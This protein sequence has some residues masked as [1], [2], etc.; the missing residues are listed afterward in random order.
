MR[1]LLAAASGLLTLSMFGQFHRAS[2]TVDLMPGLAYNYRMLA[3]KQSPLATSVGVGVQQPLGSHGFGL[4][5]G[6]YL[7]HR[8]FK[9][10][11]DDFNSSGQY[12]GQGTWQGRVYYLTLPVSVRFE[13][14]RLVV[15]GG[16]HIGYFMSSRY[17][18]RD[19][20]G[21]RIETGTR[22]TGRQEWPIG[23]QL[24]GGWSTV[25]TGGVLFVVG[26]YLSDASSAGYI[27]YGLMIRVGRGDRL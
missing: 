16:A 22:P 3:S 10:R 6:L 14:R 15:C 7:M 23:W 26:L 8:G 20:R 21:I 27:N 12:M 11:L 18:S 5:T 1:L 25:T 13:R 17:I 2:L 24:A 19:S 4:E 9:V